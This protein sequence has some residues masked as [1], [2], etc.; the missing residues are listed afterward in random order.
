LI[1]GREVS[2]AYGGSIDLLWID[3]EGELAIIELKR[4]RTPR[5]IIAQVLDYASWV[6]KLTTQSVH[7]IAS[8]HLGKSLAI[9]FHERFKS[10]L[11]DTLNENHSMVIVA[12]AFDAS[13]ERIVR[14]LSETH[15]IAINTAFFTVFENDGQVLV[16]TDWLLDQ[17]EVTER[18]EQKAKPTIQELLALAA[19]Q[20]SVELVDVFR[21]LAPEAEEGPSRAYGGSLRYWFKGR[22]ILGV[23][24]SGGRRRP[25]LGE[26]DVWIPVP[27]LSEVVGVPEEKARELLRQ[28]FAVTESGSTDCVIRIKSPAEAQS[29]VSALKAWMVPHPVVSASPE[30]AASSVS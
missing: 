4:D 28:S 2:T 22:M 6:A 3:D 30:L 23:N 15:G 24:V 7:E 29:L 14:Y 11:P 20:K 27:K 13:S 9:A 8:R 10:T 1:I 16:A 12:S 19:E 17:S 25:P 21:K 5:E 18:S 26:L